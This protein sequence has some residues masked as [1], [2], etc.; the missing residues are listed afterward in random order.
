MFI[1]YAHAGAIAG[2]SLA[3]YLIWLHALCNVYNPPRRGHVGCY[4]WEISFIMRCHIIQTLSASL[5]RV[6]NH[7]SQGAKISAFCCCV[8]LVWRSLWTNSRNIGNLTDSDAHETW[9]S[10]SQKNT[11]NTTCLFFRLWPLLWRVLAQVLLN[12]QWIP[13]TVELIFG[14]HHKKGHWH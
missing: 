13:V 4:R 1:L 10:W 12:R 6:R 8:M 9:M 5:A 7:P 3:P 2:L 14:K 11:E